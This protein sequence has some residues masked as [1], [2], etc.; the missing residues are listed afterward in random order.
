[1]SVS[2]QK[3]LEFYDS[4]LHE[5]DTEWAKYHSSEILDLYTSNSLFIGKIW[6]FD[7]KRGI[8]ILRFK[9]GKFP[10]LNI[11]LTLS[12]PK[13]SV[14][15][16]KNW[17]FSYGD[18]REY[19]AEQYTNCLPIYYLENK[20]KEDF[21]YIGVKNV[22]MS[23]LKHIKSDLENRKKSVIVLGEEDPPREYLVAL[24]KFTERNYRNLILQMSLVNMKKWIPTPLNNE[25]SIVSDCIKSI[26]NN[27][28]MVLQGPPGT[29]KTHLVAE[30]CGHYLKLEKKVCVVALTHK[31][32]IEVALKN[33]LNQPVIDGRVFKTNLKADEEAKLP[34]LKQHDIFQP[35]PES[36]LLLSTYYSF[37]KLLLEL[38][39]R[40]NSFDLVIIEEASQAFLSTIA[41]FKEFGKKLLVV[42]DFMQLQPI[43]RNN[44][45]AYKIDKNIGSIINGLRTFS[46]NQNHISYRLLNSY[47]LTPKSTN[48]TG[49]FYNNQLRSLSIINGGI[50]IG[51]DKNLFCPNGGT[52]IVN[53]K[54]MDEGRSP[55]NAIIFILKLVVKMRSK[56]PNFKIAI[57]SPY[58]TT[59]NS[60]VDRILYLNI[61]FKKLEVNTVDRI[62]GMTVDFCFFLAPTGKTSFVF[63]ENRFN[64]A[65]S[66]AKRGT[67]I[68]MEKSPAIPLL[69]AD[70][71]RMY[72]DAC[73]SSDKDGSKIH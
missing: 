66:R 18:F 11:P 2:I 65:T 54:K 70:K 12:Y 24:K 16:V 15:L 47:R 17:R 19:H 33:G 48:Q 34:Q 28:A 14:G 55:K 36:S 44:R 20:E 62:Q 45:N 3:Q 9:T 63:E 10:R 38:P 7:Y 60:I 4:Q 8:L 5:I 68:V 61:G 59:I 25:D 64:V 26:E 40:K 57:L 58:K 52:S 71:V 50:E 39:E 56:Y 41:G 22:S 73:H 69:V 42:G 49:V 32:L 27:D 46:I 53:F 23:F 37:S 21:R 31:A 29:G 30:L 43:V 35:I 67:L 51:K 13:S 1:M 6:S 72:L